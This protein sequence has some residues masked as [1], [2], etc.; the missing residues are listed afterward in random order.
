MRHLVL[1][2]AFLLQIGNAHA[3]VDYALFQK[4]TVSICKIE[5]FNSDGSV[6]IGSGIVVDRGVVATNCHVTRNAKTIEVVRGGRRINVEAQYSDVEHD[7]CLLYASHADDMPTVVL[8]PNKPRVGDSVVAVGFIG[9]LGPRLTGGEINALYDYD[10]S[11]IIQSTTPFTSGASGGGLFDGN[12]NLVG[13]VTFKY[14]NG[15]SFHFSLPAAWISNALKAGKS[16]PISPLAGVAF[17]ERIRGAQPYFLRAA[18]LEAEGNWTELASVAQQWS[19]AEADNASSWIMLGKAYHQLKKNALSIS[20]C[21]TAIRLNPE[22]SVAWYNLGVAYVANGKA[23]E[24]EQVRT[25]LITMDEN[26]ASK[27]SQYASTCKR[28]QPTLC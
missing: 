15:T 21:R 10:G 12:G 26:L 20:A 17:W 8:A 6:S 22:L 14:R 16:R 28:T 24:A 23:R 2:L 19:G 9:G 11:T 5:A 1:A 3:I 18:A 4:L 25:V 7:L 27:L 13:V